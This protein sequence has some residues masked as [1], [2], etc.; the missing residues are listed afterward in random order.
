MSLI[1]SFFHPLL[2]IN[3]IID[4]LY[5][6]YSI[7]LIF[8]TY[9]FEGLTPDLLSFLKHSPQAL[10]YGLFGPFFWQTNK[11]I[12]VLSGIENF[13][14]LILFFLFLFGNFSKR[15]LSKID[16]EAL[17]IIFYIVIVA[18]FMAFA[19]PN[20]G[21]LVRYKIGYLPFFLLLILNNNLVIAY[22]ER[23]LSFLNFS[24]KKT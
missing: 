11:L 18:L 24:E 8:G 3:R 16:I 6:N 9:K 5:T 15:K 1:A 20:W 19:S 12:T 2:N 22:I 17:S 14:L 21:S 10:L 23:N 7:I 4:A 13:V